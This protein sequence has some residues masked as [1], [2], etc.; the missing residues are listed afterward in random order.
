MTRSS[1]V[2]LFYIVSLMPVW[3]HETLSQSKTI[4]AKNKE[5][6]GLQ[7]SASAM[8]QLVKARGTKPSDLSLLPRTQWYVERDDF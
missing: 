7:G 5:G 1:R 2:I 6:E 3:L 8:T 4:V